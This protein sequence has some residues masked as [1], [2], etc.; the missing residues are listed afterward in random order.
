MIE[1][2]GLGK[3]FGTNWAVSNLTLQIDAGTFFTFLGPNGAGKTTTMKMMVGLL[4]PTTGHVR[5]AGFDVSR[6]PVS[7]KEQIGY[8]PD[9]P[10]LYGKLTGR[11]FLRFVGGLYHMP[12]AEVRKRE[13]EVLSAFDLEEEAGLLVDGYS[14]GAR[15]RLAF[16][17]CFLHNPRVVI[18]DEPWVGLDP[19]NIRNA[20]EYLKRRALEGTTIFMSTHSLTIAEQIAERIGIICHGRLIYDGTT[21][22]LRDASG[23]DLEE[24]FLELTAEDREMRVNP[25]ALP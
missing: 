5:I 1:L 17:A 15:Q 6:D 4:K 23:R 22:G 16:A 3:R 2:E 13:E 21:A 10:F 12:P 20:I 11:E 25:P 9:H 18:I 7:A 8:I 19:R 24:A 14:H